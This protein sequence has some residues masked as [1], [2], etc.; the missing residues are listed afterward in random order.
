VRRGD[1]SVG[2]FALARERVA[3]AFCELGVHVCDAD[4]FILLQLHGQCTTSPRS[5][6]RALPDD[7]TTMAL[8]GV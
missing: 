7:M 8:P 5:M 4:P 1:R 2:A 3:G 6:P